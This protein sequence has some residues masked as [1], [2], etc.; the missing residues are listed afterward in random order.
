MANTIDVTEL[1]DGARNLVAVVNIL[2]DGSGDESNTLLIDRSAYAPATGT[3][4]VID[5]LEGLLS[6]FT[7]ALSFDASTDLVFARLPDGDPFHH[8]W[9]RFGG[10]PSTKAGAGANGDVLLTTTGLSSGDRATFWLEMRKS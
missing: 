6:G 1:I 10:I 2:G 9:R 3:K 8:S 7:A 4:L 5:K